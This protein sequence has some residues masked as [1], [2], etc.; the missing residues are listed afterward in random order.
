MTL[1]DFD[2]VEKLLRFGSII[3]G[4]SL[5]PRSHRASARFPSIPLSA[6]P[7]RPSNCISLPSP[8]CIFSGVFGLLDIFDPMYMVVSGRH[9]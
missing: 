3:C 7:F 1:P 9:F 8:D 2:R 5:I 4:L 6:F